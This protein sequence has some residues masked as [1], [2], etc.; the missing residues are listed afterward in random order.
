MLWALITRR[1][2]LVFAALVAV[3]GAGQALRAVEWTTPVGEPVHAA[4]LQGNIE[5]EMKFR[6][7]RYARIVQTYARLA[8]ETSARLII[9]PETAVPRFYD[10]VEPEVLARFDA[11]AKRNG[12]DL[13][14]GVAYR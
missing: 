4:L 10:R 12:G 5:Q 14:L 7:E 11:A 13:L 6:P 9:L 3:L 2:I 8:E 1:K